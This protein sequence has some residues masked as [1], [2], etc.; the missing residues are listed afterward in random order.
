[1]SEQ[2]ARRTIELDFYKADY[3]VTDLSQQ[4]VMFSHDNT[5]LNHVFDYTK[6]S[7]SVSETCLCEVLG[8]MKST[9]V[10]Y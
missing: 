5:S 6:R 7:A 10:I 4:K 9:N 2:S 1:M 3:S 8:F